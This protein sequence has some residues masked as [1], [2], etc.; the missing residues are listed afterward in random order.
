MARLAAATDPA[1]KLARDIRAATQQHGDCLE[2]DMQRLGWT[3]A[4]LDAHREAAL[5]LVRQWN[6]RDAA[7]SAADLAAGHQVTPQTAR[8][9][10]AQIGTA[11]SRLDFVAAKLAAAGASNRR[12]P[13][14]P[15]A[16][17]AL[18]EAIDLLAATRRE[19]TGEPAAPIAGRAAA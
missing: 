14:A 8:R 4:E 19:L 3:R 2:T 5:A 17:A 10:S 15:R 11:R 13:A 1:V 9:A 7:A 18:D 16:I 6:E 12:G